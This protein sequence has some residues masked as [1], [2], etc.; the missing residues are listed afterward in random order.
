MDLDSFKSFTEG[1]ILNMD[2]QAVFSDKEI[3][4]YNDR[5]KALYKTA[6]G[7]LRSALSAQSRIA[8]SVKAKMY[9][10]KYK[11]ANRIGFSFAREGI[12]VNYGAGRGQGGTKGS[13]WI[14][15]YGRRKETNPQSFGKMGT[16]NR[17]ATNWLASI[18]PNIDELADITAVFYGDSVLGMVDKVFGKSD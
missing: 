11:I 16:G 10:S 12:Y 6:E 3:A 4:A 7:T 18:A 9:K 2:A 14:D 15:K 5:V 13:S 17:K 1:F 8:R